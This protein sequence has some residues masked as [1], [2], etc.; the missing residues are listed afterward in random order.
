MRSSPRIPNC[1]YATEALKII[2]TP[3]I[4]SLVERITDRLDNP[5]VDENKNPINV[6][7]TLGVL[8]EIK[9]PLSVD[10]MVGLLDRFDDEADS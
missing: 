4:Q 5:A 2:S 6:I 10:F 1:E 9:D 7:Y 8:S 3:A